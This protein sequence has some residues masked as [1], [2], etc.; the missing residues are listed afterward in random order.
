[1]I[2]ARDAHEVERIIHAVAE[3]E[4]VPRFGRLA[5]TDISEKAPG[6]LVT[7]ADRAAEEAL[8]AA[9]RAVVPG[10]VVVGEEAVAE[11]RGVLA[12]LDGDAPVWI[13]D[14]IDGTHNFVTDNPRFA[15]L[16]ALAHRGELMASWTYAPVLDLMA[17][18]RRG[19]GAH[20]NGERLR[21]APAPAT[22]RHLGVCTPQHKWWT[23]RNRARFN[24]LSACITP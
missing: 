20:L 9:L 21:L 19:A 1:M 17:T 14:P 13:I 8:T 24:G 23:G 3:R 15:T 5:A 16:V 12:A 10:S 22:L 7:V 2:D 11:D 4:V 6:D 18:A